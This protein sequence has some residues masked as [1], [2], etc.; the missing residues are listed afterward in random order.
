MRLVSLPLNDKPPSMGQPN[1]GIGA[2]Y[3][4]S[5]CV[6]TIAPCVSATPMALTIGQVARYRIAC[7]PAGWFVAYSW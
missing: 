2:A 5:S 1:T 4:L 3:K 7:L 6:R